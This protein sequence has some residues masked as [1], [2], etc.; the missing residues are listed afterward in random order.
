[1][2]IGNEIITTQT[3]SAPT[4]NLESSFHAS[5]TETET[6]GGLTPSSPSVLMDAEQAPPKQPNQQ[7]QAY[8]TNSM[9]NY[10]LR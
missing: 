10:L 7:N 4:E 1:M 5:A 8:A 3:E 2:Q 9:V 6:P